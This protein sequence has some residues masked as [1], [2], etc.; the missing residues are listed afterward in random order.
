MPVMNWK[1][2]FVLSVT[3]EVMLSC[4]AHS[5]FATGIPIH[6]GKFF[7]NRNETQIDTIYLPVDKPYI[8]IINVY[9]CIDSIEDIIDYQQYVGHFHRTNPSL[10]LLK[11]EYKQAYPMRQEDSLY[12][13]KIHSY[14]FVKPYISS[15][16]LN[17]DEKPIDHIIMTNDTVFDYHYFETFNGSLTGKKIVEFMSIVGSICQMKLESEE[18]IVS[19]ESGQYF[20][21]AMLFYIMPRKDSI[22]FQSTYAS[23]SILNLK[24]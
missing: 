17:A 22:S 5:F 24:N 18:I 16:Y 12:H 15:L 9:F 10:Y 21:D 11:K 7:S 3:F 19:K 20:R 4:S 2:I 8:L 14:K 13:Y 23:I 1:T 6:E